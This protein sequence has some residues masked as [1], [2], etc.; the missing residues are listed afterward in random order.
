MPGVDILSGLL[1]GFESVAGPKLAQQAHERATKSA[2][3]EVQIHREVRKKLA[4]LSGSV[5]GQKL[6]AE[7]PEYLQLGLSAMPGV[8]ESSG[9]MLSKLLGTKGGNKFDPEIATRLLTTPDPSAMA[10]DKMFPHGGTATPAASSPAPAA[11]EGIAP[12]SGTPAASPNAATAP[13]NAGIPSGVSLTRRFTGGRSMSV[14]GPT[15]LE[16]LDNQAISAIHSILNE[17]KGFEEAT[18]DLPPTTREQVG[19]G[20]ASRYNQELAGQ[21]ASPLERAQQID[22]MGL[23]EFMSPGMQRLATARAASRESGL[24]RLSTAEATA[25]ASARGRRKAQLEQPM[26]PEQDLHAEAADRGLTGAEATQFVQQKRAD[27][28]QERVRKSAEIRAGIT[29]NYRRASAST[30]KTITD[31][32]VVKSIVQRAREA[33]ADPELG[34]QIIQSRGVLSGRAID[35]AQKYGFSQGEAKDI[36]GTL[37]NQMKIIAVQ[38]YLRGVRRYEFIQDAQRHIPQPGEEI[39]LTLEKLNQLDKLTDTY[40]NAALFF[41]QPLAK[42]KESLAKG[43]GPDNFQSPESSSVPSSKTPQTAEDYLKTLEQ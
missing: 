13:A 24:G 22:S 12:I 3:E 27:L 11:A 7:H 18:T 31:I 32:S 19:K 38:P 33:L 41:D 4:E 9:G 10:F 40:T 36:W 39:P 34:P 8:D 5:E 23:G 2:A 21:G 14:R 29:E 42:V 6:L 1:R 20:L 17:G 15:R 35:L 28:Q 43:V 30:Q 37:V 16:N 26:T 25:E